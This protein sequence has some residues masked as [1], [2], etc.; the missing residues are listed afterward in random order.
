MKWALWGKKAFS[1]SMIVVLVCSYFSFYPG[2][3]VNA[4]ASKVVLVGSL[5]SELSTEAEPAGDWDPAASVT[6]MTYV[7]NGLYRFTG[8][9]P[10]GVYEYKIA[11]NGSWEESYGYGNYTNS[12]G[13][14]KDG[15]IQI[16]LAAETSVTFYY[17]DLTKKIADSTYY[18][19]V[20]ADKLPR[21]TGT[22]Q[23]ELGDAQDSSPADAKATLSDPDLDGVY[24]RSA[25]LP[26]GEYA[27]R[28]YVPGDTPDTDMFYPGGEQKLN[29][30]AASKVTFTFNAQDHGVKA[31]FTVP[32]APGA[33]APVPEGQL[34]IH[35]SR[36]A[37]DYAGLGLWMWDDVAAPSA[38]WPS[39]ATP[40]PEGQTDAYGAYVDVLLKAGAKKVSFLVVNRSTEAKDGGNKLFIINT[41]QT[42]EVWVKEGSDTVTPYEPVVL[43]ADTVRVHYARADSNWSQYGLWLW[44]EVASE[45]VTWP[46]DAVPFLAEHTDAYGAYVDVPLKA[47]AQ[48]IGFLVVNRSSGDKDGGDKT[49]RLLDRYNQLWIK[50]GDDHVYVSPFGEQPVS[51][52]SA[53]ILSTRK[54]LLTFTLTDG[55]DAAGLKSSITVTDKEGTPVPVTAA[56]IKSTTSVEVDTAAFALEKAPLSVAYSGKNV[57]ASA[58]WRM[59]DEMYNYT[60]DDLGATYH[61]ADQSATLKLWAPIAS[62][63]VANVYS[64]T[65]ASQQVGQVSLTLGDKGVWSAEL[66]P[67]DLSKA[68]AA[69]DVRGYY[70]Q[71]EVTN[72]GVTKPVL[73]PYAKSM[74]VFTVDSTGAAG[75]DGDTVGKAAIVDLSGTNPPDYRAGDIPGYEKREDAVIYEVHVR[76]FTSDVSIES[77]LGGER[78]GSYA[79]FA[80]KLDYIKSLGITHIQLMPVMAWYNGD[81]TQMTHRESGYSTQNNEYNWGYDPHSYFSPDG[82]YSQQPADP[83]ERIKELKGLIDAVHEAGM[84]VI[85]D[86]VYTH[87]AKKD[88]LDDIVPNYYAFQDANG[89]FVG[90]FGNNLATSHKMAEKLMVD[91]V[92]Y[93]FSEYKIDGM[94]WDMMGDATYDAVQ[95][96]YDAA[97][98]INPKA[99][100]IGEGWKTFAGDASD[101]ALAGKAADQAW[102]DKTDS[103]GVFS[104]E[105]RN[106]LKSGHGLEGEPRFI[107]GGARS[108]A[109]IFNNITARPSNI[110]ADDP[111]DVVPY[112]EAHD[113]LTLHDVIAYSIKKDPSIPADELEI[114]QRIRLG[115][116][117]EMTS[118][119]TA[120]IQAGQEYGRTKQWKAA[121]IPEQK[122]TEIKGANGQSFGYFIHDSYDSSDAVNMFDWA[123]ASDEVNYPVQ[124]TTRAYTSGLI[125]LRKSTDAFRLGDKNLV[126]TNVNLITAPEIKATDLVIGYK[127]KATDGTGLYYVFMNGDNTARTLTLSEDLTGGQVLVDNDQAGVKAIPAESLSGFTLT[128]TSITLDPLTAVVIRKDAAAAVLASLGTDSTGY[129]LQAG[130]THQTAVTAKYEDGSART[131]TNAA[132]YISSNP[133]VAT[134]TSKGLV[135]G[136]KPGTATITITYGGLSAKV[137]VEVT[138]E[139]VDTKRYVQITYVRDDKDYAGWNLWVWNTGVKNDQIDFSTFKDGKASVLIEVAPNATS[140]GFV[141]RKGTDWNTGKQD[142]PDDRVIPLTAGEAFTKVIVTSMVKELDIKPVINGPVMKDG[143]ITFRYRDDALFRTDQQETIGGV[144]VK[145]N[146]KEY[147]MAYEAAEEWFSYKLKD[148]QEGTYKYSFLV[149]KDGVTEE[150]TDPKNTVNGESVVAYHIPKVTVTAEVQPGAINS[151]ENAVVTVKAASEEQVSYVDGYMDLS[152]LGGPEAV[153]LDTELLQQTVAVK[154]SVPAGLKSIPITLLDQYGNTHKGTAQVEV[155]ARTYTGGQ[156]DFDWDEARIYFA[157]TDRF[158]D[159]DAANNADVDTTHPEAYHGGDFRGLIDSLDYLQ[160]LGINTLWITPVVDN[161]DFNKGADFGG[162]QYGYHGYWAKD[163]TQLD[164]HLGDMATFKELI[165]KAHD[166]GIKIMVDVV[167][168]HA[169]YGL[170]AEDNY[171]GVTA[172]DKARFDGML[173]KDGVSADTDPIKGELAGLPDFKTED[174]AVRQTLIDWQTGWLDNARTE[175]GDTIDYFRVDT[176]KHVDSTTWKAFK[177]ALTAIDPAFKL[178]GEYFGG[179]L[180]NDGGNLHSGQ[181]DGLLDF[182]FKNAAKDFTDG[183]ISVVDTYLQHREAQMDN[184]GMMAQFLSSHD[185]NGFLSNYVDGDKS[186]LKIAAALQITAKGQPVIYYG[187]ELGR[188][189][190]N[191]GDLSKGEFSENR[192]DMPWDQLS[193]EQGLHDH[194]QKLLNIRAKYSQIYSKGI[195]TKLAGSDELGYLAFDKQ[196]DGANIVT[197]I[198]TKAEAVSVSLPVPFAAQAAVVD[199]Y[200]GKTYT[201]SGDQKVRVELPG[202]GDGGTVILAVVPKVTPTPTPTATASPTPTATPTPTPEPGNGSGWNPVITATA[203]PAAD[204]QL[205]NGDSLKNGKDGKV[206]VEL[207]SGKQA[208]L[209]PL[210]AAAM[211]GTNDLVLKMS[212]LSI[213]LPVQVLRTIQGTLTGVDAE[214]AQILLGAA[215]LASNAAST[216]LAGLSKDNMSVTAASDLYDFRLEVVRKDGKRVPVT[217]F[218]EPVKLAFQLKGNPDKVLL[219]VYYLGDNSS[220]QY[221]GG[222]QQGDIITAGVT[223]FSTYA[224]LVI[225]KAY[226]DV[227]A[228]YWAETAIKSL[229]AKQVITGVTASEFKPGNPVTRAEFTAL[230]VR[231]LSLLTEGQAALQDVKAGE[232]GGFTDVKTKEQ[233]G[234]TDVKEDAWYASYVSAAVRQG[235]VTGRSKG[236]FAPDDV[237]SREEMAVMI[238]RAL[239]MKQGKKLEPANGGLR[240]ADA[241]SISSWAAAYVSAAAEQ[242]LLQGR[243]ANKFAPEAWMTR[244]EAAQVIYRLLGK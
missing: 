53:E 206:T 156:L 51:L 161:I 119:G 207:A 233:S 56:A 153:K 17:N 235:I 193:A 96:A 177:N 136:V 9:L 78:W 157:L 49:F 175:R 37:G 103:V 43:P 20:E 192:G 113:N 224:A 163:F 34:R 118:Q 87:M 129:S 203:T 243:A 32:N 120:F 124:N 214:G 187:E 196:Y 92:K 241:S 100:F 102:M 33:A 90:G 159:G 142:Y 24:E 75:P 85:L 148:V 174:P 218:A 179:T 86:V 223:H 137:N 178:T 238:I 15:N 117:L 67:S 231:A 186:K 104:D 228:A 61:P 81:E 16:S 29:L 109:T 114:Q 60:G 199:E 240:F 172:E 25:E 23:T 180:D 111:G 107:T 138:K 236:L 195:R 122:Y 220:L 226:S 41:P 36:T 71:Y 54:I 217:S 2:S 145:V 232:Q 39:G 141:L 154:N 80:K 143:T 76:D 99:L 202:R 171:P 160:K 69:E 125:Q 204:T 89:N 210:Q 40:F 237:I 18:T 19:P 222:S 27:Y 133:A 62:S 244:A 12:A 59:I 4:A 147:P 176:V 6:E 152:A 130:S 166:K 140:V 7:D 72:N 77:E 98:A 110:P 5:Q 48:K 183:K 94:R 70:Y 211:L 112:I 31:S 198:N 227:P 22:L 126:D 116:L 10:A 155:K 42:N 191:S 219:G 83:E 229:S 74:A 14:N 197:A 68:A 230:L 3:V 128:S 165:E 28:V 168:N 46:G 38:S 50:Q 66:K 205:I 146:G 162:T 225:N 150:L 93:W 139:P 134:V 58:G 47:D 21:L 11:L 149:T 239:E 8:I 208:A 79:A 184:T 127:N 151:N 201:V 132:A 26:A 164:E 55:L 95:A 182:G 181:M 64:K 213:T 106:E 221:V 173:R 158:R 57:S 135:K 144:K 84:G 115:N 188:S 91:S 194:Y 52:V 215:P 131:V 101:P 169:G 44:D 121:G 200:S 1:V 170:K 123:K 234:F 63:V 45:P 82:A 88:F 65:D 185:E 97:E 35:Y 216:L 167:L 189:G 13:V 190:A 209:L 242:G 105:F 30:P 108:I 212:G 73:D